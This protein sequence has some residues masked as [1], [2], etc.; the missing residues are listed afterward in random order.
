MYRCSHAAPAA[1]A[2]GRTWKRSSCCSPASPALLL[3]E[4]LIALT[5][6]RGSG[7][8]FRDTFR[9]S[10]LDR[11]ADYPVSLTRGRLPPLRLSRHASDWNWPN[12]SH[13]HRFRL[14]APGAYSVLRTTHRRLANN[15]LRVL[16]VGGRVAVGAISSAPFR[17]PPPSA[18]R[19]LYEQALSTICKRLV[20]DPRTSVVSTYR[21]S[22]FILVVHGKKLLARQ[23]SVDIALGADLEWATGRDG[24]MLRLWPTG[25]WPPRAQ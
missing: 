7:G 4:T 21:T 17:P 1:G 23:H 8:T 15:S 25:D 11:G 19:R 18:S 22:P 16:S 2:A 10:D 6:R 14:P 5:Y 24:Q 20:S 3:C 9:A 12:L 13:A